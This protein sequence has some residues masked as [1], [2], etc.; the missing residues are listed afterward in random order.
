M[1]S[2]LDEIDL[3]VSWSCASARKHRI[4]RIPNEKSPDWESKKLQILVSVSAVQIW[5]LQYLLIIMLILLMLSLASGGESFTALPLYVGLNADQG[6][7]TVL[8]QGSF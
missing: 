5:S 4:S 1:L 7:V 8:V 3:D 2:L 6:I